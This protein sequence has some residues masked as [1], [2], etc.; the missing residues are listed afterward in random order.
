MSENER[1]GPERD[2]TKRP[3]G[4]GVNIDRASKVEH[5]P[6][7]WRPA[8]PE[9]REGRI[10]RQEQPVPPGDR[11]AHLGHIEHPVEMYV[12]M[13]PVPNSMPVPADADEWISAF[14]RVVTDGY[15][16]GSDGKTST[17]MIVDTDPQGIAAAPL[18]GR[19]LDLCGTCR[20]PVGEPAP[21]CANPFNHQEQQA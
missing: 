10:A 17:A 5:P 14:G 18:G 21:G 6:A 16:P 4:T 7:F 15:L 8:A 20:T 1:T 2:G 12:I 9:Q 11:L 13:K 19:G 3:A